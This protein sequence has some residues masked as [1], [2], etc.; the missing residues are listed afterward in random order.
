MTWW[1]LTHRL[2]RFW[3]PILPVL[4][5][6]A[7]LGADWIRRRGWTI[8]LGVIVAVSLVIEPRV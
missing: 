8:V 2:D 3:L 5:V 7:G 1:L 4:A 6:L